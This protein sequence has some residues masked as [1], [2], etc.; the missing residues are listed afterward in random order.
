MIPVCIW[1]V[2]L[3]PVYIRGLCVCYPH[4]Q[5]EISVIPVL[6][7]GVILIPV[8]I[9]GLCVMQSPYASGDLRHPCTH[10]GSNVDPRMQT[11]IMFIAVPDLCH[12]CMHTGS[13]QGS[14]Q[15][16][17]SAIA[18]G[19]ATAATATAML[20]VTLRCGGGA[21]DTSGNSNGRGTDNNQQSTKSSNG[22]SNGNRNND[23]KDNDDG[24]K[25]NS[26][27]WRQQWQGH[28]QQST[29]N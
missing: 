24:N 22:S 17:G 9:R 13:D 27:R 15:R 21:E 28:R 8:C 11:G 6:I 23:S 14:K 20:P 16:D 25:G 1:G 10:T 18:A 26:S 2:I 4:M 3:T 19:I 7:L 5:M 29:I 12:P